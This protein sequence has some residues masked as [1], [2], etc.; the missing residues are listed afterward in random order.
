MLGRLLVIDGDI[1]SRLALKARLGAANHQVQTVGDVEEAMLTGW[2]ASAVMIRNPDQTALLRD[3]MVLKRRLPVPVIAICDAAQRAATFR[4]G[5]EYVLD[6]ACQ[7][8]VLRARLRSWMARPTE[9]EGGFS[10][11][12]S[13]FVQPDQFALLTDDAVLSSEWRCAVEAATGQ[14]LQV[15]SHQSLQ[16]QMPPKLAALLVDGGL[17]GTGLQ[18][19]AD[20]RARLLADGRGTALALLQRRELADEETRALEIGATEVLSA[21]LSASRHKAELAARLGLLLRCGMEGERR[22]SDVR[23]AR[24][25]A[26][27]DPLTGLANRRRINAEMTAT[28][29]SGTSFG[30]LMIDIDCF[31]AVNDTHGHA[32]G[33]AVLSAIAASLSDEIGAAGQ[34]ARYGGEEFLVLL[35][36]VNETEAVSLAER[37]RHRISSRQVR[38]K[39]LAGCVDLHVSVS[40]GVAVSE[41]EGMGKRPE[42]DE[43]LRQADAALL[44]AKLAGRNL[45]ML[46]RQKHAA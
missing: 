45:V 24:R 20:L 35:N 43:L 39:G 26:M 33:D 29:A 9:A 10:E 41:Q 46:G 28:A 42:V 27:V 8:S 15:L 16:T 11:A 22:H 14:R 7:D 18:Y 12:A 13:D 21:G 30:V 36:S 4:A 40:V 6:E 38:A 23:L 5:A 44:A 37:V 1:A 31:K 25:L 3:L 32:A 17:N 2:D 34:V 19:L